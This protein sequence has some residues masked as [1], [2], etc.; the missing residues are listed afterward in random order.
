M[1]T[2]DPSVS[3]LD[4]LGE[5][6]LKRV[7]SEPDDRNW[8]ARLFLA[9]DTPPTPLEAAYD[10]LLH[11]HSSK[12]TKAWATQV[13][14]AIDAPIPQPPAPPMPD[15]GSHVEWEVTAVLDQGQTGHCV[16]FGGADFE[17]TLPVNDEADN[18]VGHELY[19]ACKVV[20][21]EPD[22]EDGSSV[23]SLASVLKNDRRIEAYAWCDV[24]TL[25]DL[26]AW[27]LQKG[28]VIV[29][30]DWYDGMFTPDAD[31]VIHPTGE[32]AGGHCYL[33]V[34]YDAD[35][36]RFKILNSWSEGWGDIGC[37]FIE[38]SDMLM[39]LQNY[40]EAL[41]AVELAA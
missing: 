12:A 19:Y 8:R 14:Q 25:D 33:I 1:T 17:N 27:V 6:L 11:S 9:A 30:T 2:I 7:P 3:A 13:M 41:V 38:A 23:H 28:S 34:G 5:H 39:L 22:A 10:A 4:N 15:P 40:G 24:S 37:A 26:I 29:G 20:D 18:A 32:V 16:G 35:S 31:H 21:G 36:R